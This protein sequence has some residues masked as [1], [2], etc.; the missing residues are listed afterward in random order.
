MRS[1]LWN[2]KV[3]IAFIF[4]RS[5]LRL[6]AGRQA[7]PRPRLMELL[8]CCGSITRVPLPGAV[9]SQHTPRLVTQLDLAPLRTHRYAQTTSIPP[10]LPRVAAKGLEHLGGNRIGIQS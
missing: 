10:Y 6:T 1:S 9:S 4:P 2:G 3:M 8:Q 5:S 7:A